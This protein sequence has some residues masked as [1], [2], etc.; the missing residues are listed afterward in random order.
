MPAFDTMLSDV[1]ELVGP[2][3]LLIE[4]RLKAPIF[5]EPV[6]MPPASGKYAV[7]SVEVATWYVVVV[8]SL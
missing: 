4:V 5:M 1:R 7:R 2:A 3:M 6:M 8:S